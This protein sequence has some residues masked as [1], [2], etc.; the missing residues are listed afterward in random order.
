MPLV[1]IGAKRVVN[2]S[3]KKWR[4]KDCLLCIYCS[5]AVHTLQ[6]CTQKVKLHKKDTM[7][8]KRYE[9]CAR[10]IVSGRRLP[11][12]SPRELLESS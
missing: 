10:W 2:S 1:I 6:C 5:Y 7:S 12:P 8:N 4:C 3:S 11:R 9:I